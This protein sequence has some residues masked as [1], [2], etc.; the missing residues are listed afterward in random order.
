[1]GIVSVI[2]E[3]CKRCYACVRECPAKAIKVKE[4]QAFVIED[5]C[6]ACGNCVKVCSQNAKRIED[7]IEDV[8]ALLKQPHRKVACI[9]PSF[10]A[11]FVGVAPG[12]VITAVRRLGFDE[13]WNVA[14][15]AE[16]VAREY[17]R[18][19]EESRP[20]Q[21]PIIATPCPALVS[22]VNKYM[23]KLRDALAPIVS[24]MVATARAIR[25]RYGSQPV[26]VVFIGP[27]VAK[28]NEI[29]D[30]S[31]ESSVNSVLTFD[32]LVRFLDSEGIDIEAQ[33]ETEFDGPCAYIGGAFPLSGGLLKTSGLPADI[34]DNEILVADGKDRAL[35][36]LQAVAKGTR[37]P[38]F[39]DILFCEGCISGPYMLN[40]LSQYARKE[41]LANYVNDHK[42]WVH[43]QDFRKSIEE[44]KHVHL[45]RTFT[46]QHL[47]LPQPTED[48]IKAALL[49]M[50]KFRPEDQLNCG[51]CGYASCRDKAIAICQGLAEANMCLPFLIEEL[52][53]TCTQLQSSHRDLESAQ[54][55]LMQTE[56]LASM[57][58][59]SAGV[60]HELNNPLGTVL[61][62]SH[63]LLRQ[64]QKSDPNR[65]DLEMIVNEATRCKRI[66]RGLLDF[67][68]ES[69][70]SKSPTELQGVIDDVI[71]IMSTKSEEKKVKLVADVDRALPTM[72]IDGDQVKQMLVNLVGNGID[73]TES[74][75]GEV[76]IKVRYA[77]EDKRCVIEVIDNGK[78]IP[79]EHLSKLFT[80]FFTT[81][82]LGEGTGLGLAICYG[83][84]KMHGGDIS[85]QSEE[86]KGTVFTVTIPVGAAETVAVGE[87]PVA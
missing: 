83:I 13:V 48:E 3:R 33:A 52:E 82:E 81:K 8:R 73:A 42:R 85:A 11:A 16:L 77:E 69:R 70:V 71:V 55:R 30:P 27:C 68:R 7:S 14:F 63:M 72:S 87:L 31:L 35:A 37:K 58:Q 80:P 45:R 54:Q 1:M 39:L 56:R 26:A 84:V 43:S 2:P 9:A 53:D 76:T 19:V 4:G 51:A 41:I 57:G 18:L 34:L 67:A 6:I 23:P 47:A 79:Q 22:Y 64:V 21:T 28:K 24:P 29:R 20:S 59:L 86:G 36:A 61:I 66:V 46:P 25:Y 32:E 12:K 49:G 15:G 10:P 5:H 40:D 62:Y 74:G 17:L 65:E 50:R 60:A 75:T 78:G 44:F 38:R